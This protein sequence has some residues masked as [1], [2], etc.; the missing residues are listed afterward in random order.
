VRNEHERWDG[1]G[2]PDRL[3][4]ERIPLGSR[5][6]LACDAFDA[7]TSD[8]PYRAALSESDARAELIAG[9]GTQFDERVVSAL[10]QVLEPGDS[11][12]AVSAAR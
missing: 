4:G 5:I 9:A 8:R 3:Q 11:Q 2:Y 10:L 12:P 7:M 1:K 6:I